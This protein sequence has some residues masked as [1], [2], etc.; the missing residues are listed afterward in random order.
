MGSGY[1]ASETRPFEDADG[2]TLQVLVSVS[3]VL[4]T[5]LGLGRFSR[6]LDAIAGNE[7]F[8]EMTMIG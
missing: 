8:H 7:A 1:A 4:S 5:E 6:L 3:S 2:S